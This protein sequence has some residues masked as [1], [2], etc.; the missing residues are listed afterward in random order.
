[1]APYGIEQNSFPVTSGTISTTVLIEKSFHQ[2]LILISI[3]ASMEWDWYIT[4]KDH[5][6]PGVAHLSLPDCVV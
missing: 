3:V 1:M 2:Q 4:Q 5:D 6:G